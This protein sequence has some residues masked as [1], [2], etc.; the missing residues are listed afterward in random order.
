[1]HWILSKIKYIWS[2][3]SRTMFPSLPFLVMVELGLFIKSSSTEV[4]QVLTFWYIAEI[5]P[6]LLSMNYPQTFKSYAVLWRVKTSNKLLK[7]EWIWM[8]TTHGYKSLLITYSVSY[9]FSM[10]SIVKLPYGTL[11]RYTAA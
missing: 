4:I 7:N 9:S 3:D 6:S 5:V 2:D 11:W 10:V 8:N 1:M